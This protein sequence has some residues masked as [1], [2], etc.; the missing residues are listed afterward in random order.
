MSDLK[1]VSGSGRESV[2]REAFKDLLKAMGRAHDLV[3]IPEHRIV[4]AAKTNILVDGALLYDLRLPFGYW[5]AKDEAD[6]LDEEIAK[7]FLK[8]YPQDNIIFEHSTTAVLIQNRQEVMRCSVDDTDTLERLLD[9]FFDYQR[10]EIAEFRKAV[11]QF[12]VDLPAVLEALRAMIEKAQDE[13]AAFRAAAVKFLKHA[14]ETINPAVTADDVREML[15]QHVL[16]EEIFS[17]VFDE[18]DFHRQNNVAKEPYALESLFF[19]GALKKDK[20]KGLEPCCNAIRAT[21]RQISTHNVRQKFVKVIYQGFYKVY[22][23]KAADRLKDDGIVAFITNR[24][25]VDSRGMDG[26]RKIAAREFAEIW[27]ADL[28][29]GVRANPKISETKNNVSGIQTGVAISFLVKRN[30]ATG[31]RI[32]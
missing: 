16:T 17:K 2:E 28:G 3:F 21:A 20:L 29:G 5:E 11:A 26:F 8:G 32:F 12:Q 10:P 7:K 25:L 31:C 14:Q 23:K 19:T 22:N 24:S 6:A 9:L 18:D 4:T 30:A 15:I 27:V 1:N 13:N